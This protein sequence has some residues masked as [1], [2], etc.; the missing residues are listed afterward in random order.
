MSIPKVQ[1]NLFF[2][3]LNESNLEV[4]G[5]MIEEQSDQ[6]K[7]RRLTNLSEM[8]SQMENNSLPRF[9]KRNSINMRPGIS[10][11]SGNYS[12]LI[13][14]FN[15]SLMRNGLKIE[16]K[17]KQNDRS[18]GNI[19]EELDGDQTRPKNKSLLAR[20]TGSVLQEQFGVG[21]ESLYNKYSRK[22]NSITGPLKRGEDGILE[23]KSQL[24]PLSEKSKDQ[25]LKEES[26]AS[27]IKDSKSIKSE[28]VRSSII[29]PKVIRVKG[30]RA[31]RKSN[32][33][34]QSMEGTMETTKK[35][36]INV[37]P[38]PVNNN[39]FFK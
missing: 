6:P 14:S 23:G 25:K 12:G 13:P 32:V 4:I 26:V 34:F 8:A 22:R 11:S 16:G 21:N 37:P 2:N 39:T 38:K 18:L 5:R 15:S 19:L 28:S 35:P 7:Q 31:K 33:V 9:S 27:D 29:A 24:T 30:Y 3:L 1:K 20:N 10:F 36:V 17:E